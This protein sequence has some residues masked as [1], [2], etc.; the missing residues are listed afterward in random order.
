MRFGLGVVLGRVQRGGARRGYKFKGQGL[1]SS[2]DSPQ[3]VTPMIRGS[4]QGSAA[5]LTKQLTTSLN[6][7]ARMGWDYGTG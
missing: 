6:A 4:V 3:E 2:Q 7:A 5:R 1:G